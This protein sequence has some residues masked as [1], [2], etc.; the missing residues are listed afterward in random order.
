MDRVLGHA[1]VRCPSCGNT[2]LEHEEHNRA[3][4]QRVRCAGC[5]REFAAAEGID[6]RDVERAKK[7]AIDLV[8]G[9]VRKAFEKFK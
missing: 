9:E 7:K 6:K 1:T 2:Q 8:Q 5:G 3:L 4:K